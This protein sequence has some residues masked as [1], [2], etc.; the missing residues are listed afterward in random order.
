[1]TDFGTVDFTAAMANGSPIG[2]S[3]PTK[4]NMVAGNQGGT[5]G[6][7]S[8]KTSA[9]SGGTSFSDVWKSN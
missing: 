3:D 6:V 5:V 9:L 7:S 2:N 4:I 1:L 8:D